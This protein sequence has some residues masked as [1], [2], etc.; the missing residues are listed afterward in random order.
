MVAVFLRHIEYYR[1]ILFLT[2]NRIKT[3]DRAFVSRIHV[4]LHYTELAQPTK[5]QIWR[6]FLAKA[7]VEASGVSDELIEKLSLRD[8]NGRQIRNACRTAMALSLNREEKV[9]DCD[10]RGLER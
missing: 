6:G 1:G 7:G 8:I 9:G 10:G 3:Y 4:A 2:T 5:A